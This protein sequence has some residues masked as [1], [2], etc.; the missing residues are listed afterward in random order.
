MADKLTMQ[1]LKEVQRKSEPVTVD[2]QFS[3]DPKKWLAQQ[4]KALAQKADGTAIADVYLLAF[5][6]DG[7]VWGRMKN[8]DLITSAK[9]DHAAPPQTPSPEFRTITLQE[10][11][12]FSERG[13]LLL[14]HKAGNKF[15]ARL[16]LD[17][18]AKLPAQPAKAN[19]FD[20][21]QVLWGR[22]AEQNAGEF[23]VV[24]EGEGLRHAFPTLSG[25]QQAFANSPNGQRRPLRLR[26]RHYLDEDDDGCVYV[27]LSRLVKIEV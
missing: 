2:A 25:L 14:W 13:E 19:A 12:L 20:E 15:A 23:T 3:A 16:I 7:V 27:A 1:E 9:H 8:G 17:G 5:H 10:C 21:Q 4:A 18:D 22:Y 6:D 24:Y 26:V 11:R